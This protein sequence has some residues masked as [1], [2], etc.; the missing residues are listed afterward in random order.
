MNKVVSLHPGNTATGH[1]VRLGATAHRK[2]EDWI[3]GGSLS[4]PRAVVDAAHIQQ[5]QD[6]LATL[7]KH[8]TELVLDPKTAEL[9]TPGGSTGSA[10]T[11]PWARPDGFWLPDHFTPRLMREHAESIADFAVQHGVHAVFAPTHY[12]E[13]DPRVWTRRD[14]LGCE[15]LRDA[16]N[17]NGGKEIDIDYPVIIRQ[18]L[19]DDPAHIRA[20]SYELSQM[21]IAYVWL[22]AAGF[23]S[24]A[25][26]AGLTRY[27]NALDL[28][29][30]LGRPVILDCLG[31][32]VGL[33]SCSIGAASGL[34]HGVAEK[35]RFDSGPLR[36]P[37]N[38]G[39]GGPPR[40]YLPDLDLYV[41]R[42]QLDQVL[43]VRGVKPKLVCNDP[44]CCPNG[45]EDMRLASRRHFLIQRAQQIDSFNR[46][47]VHRRAEH[48]IREVERTGRLGRTLE[49]LLDSQNLPE[50][51]KK[52]QK[53]N[54]RLDRLAP[55]LVEL[56]ERQRR[57]PNAPP[58][59]L[60][61]NLSSLHASGY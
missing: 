40:V 10:R 44:A 30:E 34:G 59:R 54:A 28:F 29:A 49:R 21:P 38:G 47:P 13:G 60:R 14:R 39:G 3:V 55:A 7:R 42:K 36:K 23:G 6:L 48:V 9:A 61:N 43:E 17:R 56:A 11:L 16:L 4:I 50:I 46:V 15:A 32:L 31:G 19:L 27:I 57:V 53:Y 35:E 45:I 1:Y 25:T 33:A 5:Q 24:Q 58:A 2:L 8:G 52:M 26:A 51:Q 22:R 37:S 20:L 12:L 41:S 18:Q